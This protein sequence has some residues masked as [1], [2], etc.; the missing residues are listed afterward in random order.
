MYEEGNPV[1]IKQTLECIGICR[2]YVRLPLDEASDSLKA[3]ILSAL[4]EIQ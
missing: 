1:G 2:H 3:K 4:K